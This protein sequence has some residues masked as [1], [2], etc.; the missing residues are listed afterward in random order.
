MNHVFF[1]FGYGIPKNILKDEHYN[2]YLKTVFNHIYSFVTKKN[3]NTPIIICSGGKTDLYKPYQR[4]E[5]SEMTKFLKNIAQRP[6]LKKITKDWLFLSEKSS[7]STLENFLHCQTIL[8]KKNIQQANL[9]IFCEKT[10]EYRIQS[11]A[12][13]VLDKHDHF[14]IIPID[15]DISENR[16]LDPQ[17]IKEKEQS[18]LQHDLW[19]LKTPE[20]LKKYHKLFEKKFEFLR[21]SGPKVHIQTLREWWK[22]EMKELN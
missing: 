1:V 8:K 22:K 16:Y 7:L 2:F 13:H 3:I 18:V 10:R 14:Q 21:K 20:N 12:K 15:F 11:I 17:F 5:G 6:F 19:A 9:Y 4:T